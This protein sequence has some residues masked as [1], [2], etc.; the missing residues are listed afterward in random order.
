MG[1]GR[2]RLNEL[3][4]VEH[5]PVFTQGLAGKP[6]HVLNPGKIPIVQ[7]DRGGQVTYHGPGQVGGLPVA[8]SEPLGTGRALPWW[9]GWSRP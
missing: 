2:R 8:G 6:E 3:W 9:I 7:S 1:V 5:D 4:V